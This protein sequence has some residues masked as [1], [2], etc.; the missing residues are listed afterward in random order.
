[1][2]APALR[3]ENLEVCYEPGMPIVRGAS[4]TV[5][6]GEIVAILGPNGAGKSSLAKAVAGL[7]PVTGGR[8]LL[9]GDDITRTPAHRMVFAGLAFVPQTDN[10]FPNLS[11]AENLELA[12]AVVH[13][14]SRRSLEE[15]YTMFPDLRTQR[16]LA[17]GALSGGQRQMLA[18]ARALIARPRLMILDEPSAGLSPKMVGLVF[19]ELRKARA[20]G[21]S[22]L[23]VEQNVNAALSLADRAVILVEGKERLEGACA[24][25]R[26]D[27][28]VAELYLGSHARR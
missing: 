13:A 12:A 24:D 2:N 21:L 6:A 11:V 16:K 23:I 14:A 10:V 3:V 20:G 5:E 4:L 1:M 8:T 17:A 15:I 22:I 25:L 9:F 19:D 7:A 27:A 18:I 26:G 28:A